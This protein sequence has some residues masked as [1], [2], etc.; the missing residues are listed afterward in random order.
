[1]R[2]RRRSRTSPS[3]ACRSR[4][5]AHWLWL[6]K[7]AAARVNRDLGLLDPK[8]ADAIER[9][10]HEGKL[11]REFPLDVF[12]TGSGTSTNMNANEVIANRAELLGGGR[13][14]ER[15]R[16]PGPVIE[17]RDPHGDPRRAFPS[18]SS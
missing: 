4:R 15:P 11:D 2:P 6:V 7:L 17:R 14:S 1:M 5:V 9:A 18:S 8:I 13:P 3:R 16:E 10:S 12:Q